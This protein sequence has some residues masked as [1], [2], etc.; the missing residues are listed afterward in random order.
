[1]AETEDKGVDGVVT[2]NFKTNTCYLK[3]QRGDYTVGEVLPIYIKA[4]WKSKSG[5]VRVEE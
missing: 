5:S 4:A 2:D 1:M 3:S